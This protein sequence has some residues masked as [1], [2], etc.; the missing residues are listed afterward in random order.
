MNYSKSYFDKDIE[1]LDYADIEK[2]FSVEREESNKIEFKSYS[3]QHGNL[4]KNL[5]LLHF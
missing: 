4:N 1:E 5:V 3:Q 2:Y